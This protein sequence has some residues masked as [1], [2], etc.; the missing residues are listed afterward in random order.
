LS[1]DAVVIHLNALDV[2]LVIVLDRE[3]R[4]GRHSVGAGREVDWAQVLAEWG[5]ATSHVDDKQ[6]GS[7]RI[8]FDR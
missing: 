1:Q 2:E 8:G 6:V 4:N 3:I 5:V 7:G